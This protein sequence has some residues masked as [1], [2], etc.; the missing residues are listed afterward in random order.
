MAVGGAAGVRV[1]QL[2]VQ[3]AVGLVLVELVAG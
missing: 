2:V 1:Y 3:V